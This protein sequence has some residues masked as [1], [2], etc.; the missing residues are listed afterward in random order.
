MRYRLH[1]QSDVFPRLVEEAGRRST[2]DNDDLT[3]ANVAC[4]W[5]ASSWRTS[6]FN[7]ALAYAT[8]SGGPR[9]PGLEGMIALRYE[10]LDIQSWSYSLSVTLR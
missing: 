2:S 7:A 9:D 3:V 6:G 5:R 10:W 1:S 4:F 8:G